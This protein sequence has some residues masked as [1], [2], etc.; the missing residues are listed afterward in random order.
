MDGHSTSFEEAFTVE[1]NFTAADSTSQVDFH[2]VQRE[3]GT[4]GWFT[5]CGEPLQ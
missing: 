1:V 5:D 4:L 3:D 2:L